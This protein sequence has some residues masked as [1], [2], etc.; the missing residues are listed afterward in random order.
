MILDYGYDYAC[1]KHI[2]GH[3]CVGF[4]TIDRVSTHGEHMDRGITFD[5]RDTRTH[6]ET[7]IHSMQLCRAHMQCR[8]PYNTF[9]TITP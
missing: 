6:T 4:L 1:Y 2:P 9:N 7:H 5:N 8:H 3:K